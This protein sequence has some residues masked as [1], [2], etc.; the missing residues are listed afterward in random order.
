MERGKDTGVGIRGHEGNRAGAGFWRLPALMHCAMAVL[1]GAVVVALLAPQPGLA[2]GARDAVVVDPGEAVI[3]LR[4]AVRERFIRSQLQ[5]F[6]GMA[7]AR[8][9]EPNRPAPP[10]EE[11][12]P[13]DLGEGL[14]LIVSLANE[15]AAPQQ[16]TLA[17]RNPSLAGAGVLGMGQSAMRVKTAVHWSGDGRVQPLEWSASRGAVETY[18]LTLPAGL[19]THV[20]LLV[21]DPVETSYALS[22]WEPGAYAA[23]ER[24]QATARG[25]L[26]GALL[27]LAALVAGRW[28]LEGREED[29]AATAFV[30]TAVLLLAATLGVHY[31][32][33]SPASALSGGM[34][35][36]ALIFFAAAGLYFIHARLALE[37]LHPALPSVLVWTALGGVVLGLG[38][39]A[40]VGIELAA[41][42][43]AA[44][45][46]LMAL[47]VTVV[48][49]RRGEHRA[50]ALLPGVVF[51]GLC[52]VAAGVLFTLPAGPQ[53]AMQTLLLST[54][55]AA[56]TGL[57]TLAAVLGRADEAGLGDFE[58]AHT[59]VG[60]RALAAPEPSQP[61]A[62]AT[63]DGAARSAL[64]L[65]AAQEGVFDL[66]VLT[67]HVFVS[68]VVEA[69]MGLPIGAMTGP[70]DGWYARLHPDDKDVYR[71]AFES[72]VARGNANFRLEF[73]IRHED[74]SHR[75]VHLKASALPGDE[76][77]AN[78]VIGLLSDIAAR[79]AG[80]A[81][82]MLDAL[83]DR[84]T[85]LANRIVL[86][87]RM[88]RILDEDVVGEA[89]P[90]ALMVIDVDRFKTINEALGQGEGDALLIAV[91]RRLEQLVGP[92]D[93]VARI[94][95]D[96]FAVF[97]RHGIGDEGF[98]T[99]GR[100]VADV[101][102]APLLLDGQEVS[103][104]V[105][106]GMAE[107]R[108]EQGGAQGLLQDAEIALYGAKA[109]GL[110]H[111]LV[112]NPSMR[113]E[114]ADHQTRGADLKRAVE[115]GE[116]ELFYQP[117]M[118][119]KDGRLSG[120][121]AVPR[122]RHPE[123]GLLTPD[124]FL[125]GVEDSDAAGALGRHAITTLLGHIRAWHLH[126]PMDPPLFIELALDAEALT[127]PD[128][129]ASLRAGLGEDSPPAGSVRLAVS[130]A[131][132]MSNPEAAGEALR[133]A[134][135]G[136]AGLTLED[137]GSGVSSLSAVQKYP[138][139]ALKIGRALVT[140]MRTEPRI[141]TIA[142]SIVTLAHDLEQEVIAV[143]PETEDDV[144]RLRALGCDFAQGFI[145]GNPLPAEAAETLL[146]RAV[147]VTLVKPLARAP[148]PAPS[149][150]PE[151][152]PAEAETP[153]PTPLTPSPSPKHRGVIGPT[154]YGP[155]KVVMTPPPGA[156]AGDG[157]QRT[158]A[159][160][161]RN[162][163]FSLI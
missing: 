125:D 147:G 152:A 65:D 119:L 11:P 60:E 99:A 146:A 54:A 104:S 27:V 45:A 113:G 163:P 129:Q 9:E 133:A 30:V 32:I 72:Y 22:L 35:A 85:G 82:L 148:R 102:A 105:S 71:T 17:L 92:D 58:E 5:R 130:E 6:S 97:L 155:Y 40:G 100:I 10:P 150:A 3:D 86:L 12:A 13:A 21:D 159:E 29:L 90:P 117:V 41:G 127:H 131:A 140:G 143:G 120:F 69:M 76:G 112:F 26:L 57:C 70:H 39:L 111:I 88:T 49:A 62:I 67:E 61:L 128:V 94:G 149:P 36:A 46:A 134:V 154:P 43:Y 53:A 80:E 114:G 77:R 109:E 66:D 48:M 160:K 121:E 110:G 139:T 33:A 28:V 68:P 142:R 20:A 89:S 156:A 44:L 116:I 153:A 24:T 7:A 25:A 16:R 79:K 98:E 19:T 74:G 124:R 137:F 56:G 162:T 136:G 83:H 42:P 55:V 38:A 101:L 81:Q 8:N 108:S 161:L 158:A 122:W 2:Q 144:R 151:P 118:S 63:G 96:E 103:P 23:L 4:G 93:T 126:M 75:W 106:I 115:A 51:L 132:F 141:E 135:D 145:F 73:R 18:D 31:A 64:A 37:R 84:L 14:W 78:R 50:P 138:F 59:R 1:L 123:R 87:D 107:A 34:R 91:A 95:G 157:E 47:I 52:A 15:G